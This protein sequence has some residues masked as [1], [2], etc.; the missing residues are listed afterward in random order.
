MT[1]VVQVVILKNYHKPTNQP[2]NTCFIYTERESD[3]TET[4][5]CQENADKGLTCKE[6]ER[7]PY[8]GCQVTNSEDHRRQMEW[9]RK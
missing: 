6:E 4:N 1:N 2:I 9:K 5:A 3:N 7:N 8:Q